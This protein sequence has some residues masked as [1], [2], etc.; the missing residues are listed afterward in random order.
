VSR[1]RGGEEDEPP[2]RIMNWG[3]DGVC[4]PPTQAEHAEM[5]FRRMNEALD[6][7]AQT[8]RDLPPIEVPDFELPRFEVQRGGMRWMAPDPRI[9]E[10]VSISSLKAGDRVFILEGVFTVASVDMDAPIPTIW[11]KE[12][13]DSPLYYSDSD[14]IPRAIE[15]KEK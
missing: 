6:R 8:L 4:Q 11:L 2:T 10:E 15:S 9:G 1:N 5:S 7:L 3:G 12:L 13:P 14:Y